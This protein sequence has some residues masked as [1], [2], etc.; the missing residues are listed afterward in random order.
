MMELKILKDL[1]CIHLC[2]NRNTKFCDACGIEESHSIGEDD[3][4]QEAIK[5]IKEINEIPMKIKPGQGY[6]L[7]PDISINGIFDEDEGYGAYKFIK[8]FFNITEA[9]LCGM[10]NHDL[11]KHE[12]LE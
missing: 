6:M 3:L 7:I 12:D 8:H 1:T 9:E 11:C 10:R 5:W 2:T 4:R